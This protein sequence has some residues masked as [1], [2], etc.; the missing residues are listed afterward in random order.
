MQVLI[1]RPGDLAQ[2]ITIGDHYTDLQRALAD[3]DGERF[4]E[5]CM[6]HGDTV[7][8]CDEEFLLHEPLPA[9]N[10]RRPSD[11]H[12]LCGVLIAT[13]TKQTSEGQANAD[14]EPADAALWSYVFA[15]CDPHLRADRA[16]V[17]AELRRT[18]TPEHAQ[19]AD[20]T[21]ALIAAWEPLAGIQFRPH[22]EI[23][24]WPEG[25]R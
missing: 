13:G 7:V 18:L 4:F 12:P 20:A 19:L 1:K 24:P 23:V 5:V 11:G 14:I 8:W 16:Q 3:G 25:E 6:S 21:D 2:L 22:F 17:L 10:V 9:L 15:A